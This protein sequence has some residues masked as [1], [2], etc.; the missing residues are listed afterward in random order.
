VV[1]FFEFV[2]IVDYVDGFTYIK[3][4]LHPCDEAVCIMID[5]CFNVVLDW[6]CENFIEYFYIDIH[7]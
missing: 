1:V 4:S 7:K 3:S 6:T 2:C 5:D